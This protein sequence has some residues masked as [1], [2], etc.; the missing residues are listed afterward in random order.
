MARKSRLAVALVATALALALVVAAAW[1]LSGWYGAGPLPRETAFVVPQGSSLGSIAA[2]L[3]KEHAIR[4][5]EAFRLR[6]RLL[7]SDAPIRAGEFLLPKA[8]SPARVLAKL[9]SND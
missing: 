1:F 6:A 8:A 4:S 3:E 7:G 9:Q 5:A 2:K